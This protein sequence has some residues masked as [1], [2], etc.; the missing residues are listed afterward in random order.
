MKLNKTGLL[1]DFL[2]GK[3]CTRIPIS[4]VRLQ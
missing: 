4:E 1:N 3:R 2:E